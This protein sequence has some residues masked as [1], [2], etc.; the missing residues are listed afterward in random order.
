MARDDSNQVTSKGVD[1][2]N[3]TKRACRSALTL[4]MRGGVLRVS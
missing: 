3:L 1:F 2:I 4:S